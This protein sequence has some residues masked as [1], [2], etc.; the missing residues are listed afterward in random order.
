MRWGHEQTQDGSAGAAGSRAGS[1]AG[2]RVRVWPQL[3]AAAE[4][5]S[6]TVL[7]HREGAHATAASA[8]PGQPLRAAGRAHGNI[9]SSTPGTHE[10]GKCGHICHGGAPFPLAPPD[11][12]GAG[13]SPSPST[14]GRGFLT[15]PES[16]RAAPELSPRLSQHWERGR[17]GRRERG[18]E[19]ISHC[20][21]FLKEETGPRR[22]ELCH[23]RQR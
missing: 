11:A 13:L 1:R 5:P 6:K 20:I 12:V 21:C 10:P 18:R 22:S 2:V 3:T 9:S 14:P 23:P 17:E 7:A 4:P 15:K 19:V 16:V 8:A